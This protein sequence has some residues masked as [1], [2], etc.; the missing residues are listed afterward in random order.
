MS[1]TEDSMRTYYDNVK[2]LQ[3]LFTSGMYTQKLL[4][5]TVLMVKEML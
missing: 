3:G 4:I 1:L 5:D 2:K